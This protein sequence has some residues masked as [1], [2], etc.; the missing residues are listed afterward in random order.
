MNL[1]TEVYVKSFGMTPGEDDSVAADWAA[2]HERTAGGRSAEVMLLADRIIAEASG[3]RRTAQAMI[4][5]LVALLNMGEFRRLGPLMDDIQA[6]LRTIDDPRLRGEFRAMAG[7][8]AFEHGSLST[9]MTNLVGAERDLRR[10]TEVSLAAVDTWH[11]LSVAYS[12]CGFHA[13]AMEAR[14]EAARLCGIAGLSPALAALVEARVRAAVG[15]D[16]RGD[17]DGCVRELEAVV[18][19]VRPLV[20]D[21][22]V[23][24]R[25]FLRYAVHRLAALG[26]PSSL[27]IPADPAGDVFLGDVNR[28]ADVCAALTAHDPALALH[29]LDS[30]PRAID[31]LGTA[32]PLRLR[33]LAL[34]QAGDPGGALA[35]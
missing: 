3:P 34:S 35:A 19:A 7:A 30:A 21:L 12:A 23:A 32:E 9:A 17:A 25:I 26:H 16:Q 4:E 27:T 5:K 2:F 1:R 6:I 14:D 11:D 31:V 8:V 24:E 28:L 29:L 20:A 15:L 10:M 13:K 33:S 22:G 18:L